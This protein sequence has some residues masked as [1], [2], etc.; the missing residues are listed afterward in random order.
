MPKFASLVYYTDEKL[1]KKLSLLDLGR[2]VDLLEMRKLTFWMYN[3]G[4][5]TLQKIKVVSN[6]KRLVVV[7]ASTELLSKRK[8]SVTVTWTPKEELDL[9]T[10]LEIS[11]VY[12]SR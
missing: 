12:R 10:T 5:I 2:N 11:G 6:D 1:T 7:D 4:N 3:V 9:K 8:A